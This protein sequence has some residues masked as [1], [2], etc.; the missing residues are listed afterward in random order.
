[1][2]Y[3]IYKSD[4][5]GIKQIKLVSTGEIISEGDYLLSTKYNKKIGPVVFDDVLT[6]TDKFWGK[7]Y[8]SHVRCPD[9][10]YHLSEIKTLNKASKY[11][12]IGL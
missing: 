5:T 4:K 3:E 12:L 6:G 8:D 1:M 2:M 9:G 11:L 10:I 7:W